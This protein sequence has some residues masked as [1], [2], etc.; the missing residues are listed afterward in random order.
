MLVTIKID[1][2]STFELALVHWYDFCYKND[3]ILKYSLGTEVDKRLL[4]QTWQKEFY[5][6]G[7]RALGVS[8]FLSCEVG[9]HFKSKGYI[10][11]Q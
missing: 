8:H 7:T 4:E 6:A 9:P 1:G 11:H 2:Y 5:R 3:E 10:D